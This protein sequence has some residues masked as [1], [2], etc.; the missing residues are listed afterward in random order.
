[1]FII[2]N[3]SWMGPVA[4]MYEQIGF[5]VT[6]TVAKVIC[7]SLLEKVQVQGGRA[8]SIVLGLSCRSHGTSPG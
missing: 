1:M 7:P 8:R 5:H 3:V 6:D 4:T 2:K